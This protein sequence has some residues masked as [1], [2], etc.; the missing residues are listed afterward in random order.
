M[1]VEIIKELARQWRNN[2]T[3]NSISIEAPPDDGR[4]ESHARDIAE[5]KKQEIAKEILLQ[6]AQDLEDVVRIYNDFK[7]PREITGRQ[8]GTPLAAQAHNPTRESER[9]D[10]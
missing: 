5:L 2:A 6:C 10:Y 3:C 4:G 9:L 7:Y 1:N 8:W